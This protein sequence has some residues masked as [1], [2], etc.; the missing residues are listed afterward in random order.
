MWRIYA[1][2]RGP[3]RHHAA[4]SETPR[5]ARRACLRGTLRALNYMLAI[6]G[7]IVMSCDFFTYIR[8]SEEAQQAGWIAPTG[9]AAAGSGPQQARVHPHA[10][11]IELH[12][13]NTQ[14]YFVV[15]RAAESLQSDGHGA[16]TDAPHSNRQPTDRELQYINLDKGRCAAIV[17]FQFIP[18]LLLPSA[19]AATGGRNRLVSHAAC[20]GV[21]RCAL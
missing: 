8:W 18:L 13:E 21:P 10:P 1:A 9:T 20:G 6:S 11:D 17:L 4:D 14:S 7:V 2:S 16:A 19:P 5:S 3:P 15:S 12:A